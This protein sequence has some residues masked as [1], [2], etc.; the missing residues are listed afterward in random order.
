[1]NENL[2]DN[3]MRSATYIS[4]YDGDTFWAHVNVLPRVTFFSEMPFRIRV[5]GY[6]AAEL[7]EAEGPHLRDFFKAKLEAAKEIRLRIIGMS[8]DRI[9]C[10][11]FLDE[12]M[13]LGELH[14]EIRRLR[15]IG[16]P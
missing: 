5:H 6:N 15:G 13:F 4:T 2:N 3:R 12:E 7:N 16:D 8:Y 11:V 9:V 1:M 14:Q 10:D